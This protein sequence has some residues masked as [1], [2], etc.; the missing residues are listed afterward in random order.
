MRLIIEF[1]SCTFIRRLLGI[2]FRFFC[3]HSWR[4]TCYVWMRVHV[5]FLLRFFIRQTIHT[6]TLPLKLFDSVGNTLY[7][8]PNRKNHVC[9]SPRINLSV[10][11]N[12][13]ARKINAM[14]EVIRNET[15]SNEQKQAKKIIQNKVKR[16][17]VIAPL[18]TTNMHNYQ[19][20]SNAVRAFWRGG[21][22]DSMDFWWII[23]TKAIT[24]L[25]HRDESFVLLTHRW[26]IIFLVVTFSVFFHWVW[27][28]FA[29][30]S[31]HC[32]VHEWKARAFELSASIN[33][34]WNGKKSAS[35]NGALLFF[36]KEKANNNK[37]DEKNTT[38]HKQ[39]AQ[40]I[41]WSSLTLVRFYLWVGYFFLSF[42]L[43]HRNIVSKSGKYHMQI[44]FVLSFKIN[45]SAPQTTVTIFCSSRCEF[46]SFGSRSFFCWS[47]F[48]LF[49]S[50]FFGLAHKNDVAHESLVFVIS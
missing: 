12:L 35:W 23:N 37:H 19:I 28:H 3:L 41:L 36:G 49:I 18:S 24:Q 4:A 6:H 13:L 20:S 17:P 15:K 16:N 39:N 21:V 38:E 44:I 34:K 10:D 31:R 30:I 1:V 2:H 5:F 11:T 7:D 47:Y 26:I 22:G 40:S 27:W 43:F 50:S 46:L 25:L 8:P 32:I 29:A 45:S 42:L 48:F 33:E 9:A 14:Q